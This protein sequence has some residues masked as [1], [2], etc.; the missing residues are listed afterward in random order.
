MGVVG[1]GMFS[2]TGG[3]VRCS[4]AV[5]GGWSS[6]PPVRVGSMVTGGLGGELS[7]VGSG[8]DGASLFFETPVGSGSI[9]V[10]FAGGTDGVVFC[11][12]CVGS[13]A[14][15]DLGITGT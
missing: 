7:L 8:L 5:T 14:I 10:V 9:R 3:H 2:S 4:G 1:E 6:F 11:M 13:E 15:G 12:P